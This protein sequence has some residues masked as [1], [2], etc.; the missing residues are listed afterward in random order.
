MDRGSAR[1]YPGLKRGKDKKIWK[2]S[3]WVSNSKVTGDINGGNL[4]GAVGE[5][6]RRSDWEQSKHRYSHRT[7]L[8][9]EGRQGSE[10]AL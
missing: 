9:G 3:I 7:V 6:L 4:S 2:V 1:V 5:R 8:E 10:T